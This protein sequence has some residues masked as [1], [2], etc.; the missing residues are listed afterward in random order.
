[1]NVNNTALQM[2]S[3]QWN[4]MSYLLLW[5]LEEEI[6]VLFS[7]WVQNIQKPALQNCPTL[8]LGQWNRAQNVVHQVPS[9]GFP[10]P[11][12]SVS[13]SHKPKGKK[14]NVLLKPRLSF[15]LLGEKNTAAEFVN[16]ATTS[17]ETFHKTGFVCEAVRQKGTGRITA[18]RQQLLHPC[19]LILQALEKQLEQEHNYY[20][21]LSAAQ[22]S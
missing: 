14:Q 13:C 20:S 19:R 15:L 22:S 3:L 11:L 17:R 18:E 7:V 1:M 8:S 21:S 12:K 6:F 9:A 2:Y 4:W 10:F 16:S 5:T